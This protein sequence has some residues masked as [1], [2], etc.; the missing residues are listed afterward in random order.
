M[1]SSEDHLQERIGAALFRLADLGQ[2]A[3]HAAESPRAAGRLLDDVRKLAT[4]IERTLGDMRLVAARY[5]ELRDQAAA[6]CRRGDRLFD[7]V[8]VACLLIDQAAGTIIDA[9]PAAVR[10]LNVSHR[11]IVGR[12]FPLFLNGDRDR[13]VSRLAHLG[14]EPEQ[15]ESLL[16]P[17]ERSAIATTLTAWRD[18]AD[19]VFVMIVPAAAASPGET[20]VAAAG[21]GHGGI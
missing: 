17:R 7:A 8:P 18:S 21:E 9:N 10:L 5:A 6:A 15:A 3:D 13:F 11:H 20:L 14:A 2:R 19:V 12:S 4:E 1:Q 16:R